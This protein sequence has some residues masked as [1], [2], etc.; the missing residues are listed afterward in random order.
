MTDP[1]IK[2]AEAVEILCERGIFANKEAA[3]KRLEE[4]KEKITG[5]MFGRMF[6]INHEIKFDDTNADMTIGLELLNK[7]ANLLGYS[8]KTVRFQPELISVKCEAGETEHAKL[9]IEEYMQKNPCQIIGSF[10]KIYDNNGSCEILIPICPLS[11]EK[12]DFKNENYDVPFENDEDSIGK[13]ELV[14]ILPSAEQFNPLK[15]KMTGEK[16]IKDLYFLSN[17]EKYWIF[18]WTKG[19]LFS[20]SFEGVTYANIYV[21][22]TINGESYLFLAKKIHEIEL[23]GGLP[24]IWVFKKVSSNHFTANEVCRTDNTDLPFIDDKEV[25]GKWTVR[26]FVKNISDF[27]PNSQNCPEEH[28]YFKTVNFEP[29]GYCTLTYMNKRT[30]YNINWTNGSLIYIREKKTE[31]YSLLNIEGKQYLFIQWKNGD[32]IYG[33]VKPW[34]YVFE[35]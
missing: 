33:G 1:T 21:I 31:N 7:P 25:S 15:I 17:G 3:L 8:I 34:Y 35:R 2:T 9:K 14:D 16:P 11:N 28:L 10:Y 22:R 32:Y 13:W 20:D 26:D 29:N 6:L 19:V 23:H 24:V 30:A 4:M 27:S 18:H 5:V 12:K